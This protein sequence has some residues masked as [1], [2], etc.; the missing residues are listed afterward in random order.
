LCKAAGF[1]VQKPVEILAKKE[2][3]KDLKIARNPL[4]FCTFAGM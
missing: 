1:S 3:N 4:L 2:Q